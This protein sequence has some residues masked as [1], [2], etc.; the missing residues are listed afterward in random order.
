MWVWN[1]KME[2]FILGFLLILAL[3]DGILRFT[4]LERIICN[5]GVAF[6]IILPGFLLWTFVGAL[7]AVSVWQIQ[8][9]REP[10]RLAWWAILIG[11]FVNAIDRL[12]YGCVHDYL[13][14][15]LFPS[16]NLADMMLFLG[17]AYL[18]ARMT[19]IFSTGK[20]YVS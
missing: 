13:T 14:I 16:F 3:G 2:R 9:I 12:F 19:G 7:L 5:D 4:I 8:Q 10:M 6:G 17:V 11:G 20:T 1:P 18:L 15:P